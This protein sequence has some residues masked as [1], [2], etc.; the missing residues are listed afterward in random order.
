M[1]ISVALCDL[2]SLNGHC[3]NYDVL[4]KTN[5]DAVLK[6]DS[7]ERLSHHDGPITQAVSSTALQ[8]NWKLYAYCILGNFRENFIF[9]NCIKRH[10]YEVK[11]LRLGHD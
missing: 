7:G 11:N 4:I 6:R 9:A 3:Q 2:V 10:I 1:E 8:C 5:W